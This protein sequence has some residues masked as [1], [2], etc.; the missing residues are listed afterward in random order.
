[1][2]EQNN[3]TS[4][5]YL[6]S[7]LNAIMNGE[8]KSSDS[9]DLGL[10][11][12][13][14]HESNDENPDEFFDNIED[15]LF[16]NV[17]DSDV[18]IIDDDEYFEKEITNEELFDLDDD[19]MS[20]IE[21]AP[22]KKKEENKPSEEAEPVKEEKETI[23][24][25]IKDDTENVEE[26][27]DDVE[28]AIAAN[29]SA[30]DD[31]LQGLLDVM[32]IDEKEESAEPVE[33]TKKK[34]KEKKKLFGRK[35]GKKASKEDGED[36]NADSNELVDLSALSGLMDGTAKADV[37][38]NI[39]EL[40]FGG[41]DLSTD[42]SNV[43]PMDGGLDGF[44]DF[45]L[46][47]SGDDLGEGYNMAGGAEPV[48]MPDLDSD[49]APRKPGS[50]DSYMYD[51]DFD[52]DDNSKKKGKKG[53]K[54]KDKKAKV[55]KAK[56]PKKVKTKE[57]KKR[58]KEADE[59]IKISKGF[60]FLAF[61]FAFVFIFTVIFGGDY[62]TYNKKVSD[63]TKEYVNKNYS[64]AYEKIFGLEMK[65][66]DD[67][68]LFNQIQ[69]VMFVNRHY[70]A[71]ESLIRMDEYEQGLYSLLK[72]VKMFDKYQNE[73]RKL[74][75]YDDMQTVLGWID[76]G[77]LETYGLTESQARE[78]NLLNNDDKLA[79]EVAVIAQ[80]AREKA[81]AEAKAREE[82]EKEAAKEENNKEVTE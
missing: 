71:Y 44:G 35:K 69:T 23:H 73:G 49:E 6:D 57:K 66:D 29:D 50:S 18:E 60:V 78:L 64:V 54:K 74:N 70:E 15:E 21:S 79:Y 63:A 65:R 33:N 32:G 7:L 5:D 51:D 22:E 30:V 27:Q 19:I 40:D 72:G 75:C 52:E 36:E 47:M 3:T 58:D 61:S 67:K 53:K 11:S 42:N 1:M 38:N 24:E 62:Y 10:F 80:E 43:S 68:E 82:A 31:N 20:I 76:R 34:K 17:T 46:D 39:G 9:D 12:D 14:E 4:E 8:S 28:E 45:D 81:E 26:K 55:K 41:L 48:G 56:I 77:L 25:I 59:I 13:P 16:G 2:K 37:D